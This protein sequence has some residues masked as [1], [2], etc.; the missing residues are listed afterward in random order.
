MKIVC[1]EPDRAA[2]HKLSEMEESAF[3]ERRSTRDPDDFIRFT[4]QLGASIL[5]DADLRSGFL[6]LRLAAE[7]GEIID[8]GVVPDQRRQGVAR[9]L[10]AEAARVARQHGAQELFLEVDVQ[11]TPA[12]RLYAATGFAEVGL[13]K[14]YYDHGQGNRSDAL[15]LRRSL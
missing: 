12:K 9:K 2:A 1:I 6:M 8:L 3:P 15:I 10:V 14:G 4:S 13:R 7:E 5:G 11:N